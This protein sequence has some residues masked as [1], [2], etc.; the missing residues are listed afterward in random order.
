MYRNGE[1][2]VIGK[3]TH[4][5]D[6]YSLLRY[7]ADKEG[8][9]QVG[10]NV[11][12]NDPVN[13]AR[14][15]RRGQALHRTINRYVWHTSLSTA[16][17]E[18]L[19]NETWKKIAQDYLREM[20]FDKHQ[21]VVYRHT[22][23]DHNHIHIVANRIS[24]VDGSAVDDAWSKYR[25]EAAIRKLESA[26]NLQV[27]E[28][29][30]GKERKSPT[31]GE[32]RMQARTQTPLP[33]VVIQDA[34]DKILPTITSPEDLKNKLKTEGIETRFRKRKDKTI[35]GISFSYNGIAFG[36]GKLGKRYSWTRIQQQLRENQASL[37]TQERSQ[38]EK[39]YQ[40]L[41]SKFSEKVDP[42]TRDILIACRLLK[43]GYSN[44]SV[45]RVLTQSPVIGRYKQS[46]NYQ[47]NKAL[48]YID[49]IYRKAQSAVA[50]SHA[51]EVLQ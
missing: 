45:K 34:L 37:V 39:V 7:V 33:R 5:R 48:R 4:G 9:Y 31:T 17:D 16:K 46:E 1:S 12:F 27:V 38:L 50:R 18:N 8:A 30:R 35:S 42:Q 47:R 20:G 22:D 10:G 3:V 49:T 15:F 36:G 25:T 51:K 24:I 32:Q 2:R 13:I 21:Y 28:P 19:D 43:N 40:T 41:A 14:E 44:K 26:Y 29:S 23:A 6:A 11:A